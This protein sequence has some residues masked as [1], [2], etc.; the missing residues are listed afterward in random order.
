VKLKIGARLMVTFAIVFAFL[1]IV[2]VVATLQ[3]ASMNATTQAIVGLRAEELNLT[4]RVSAGAYRA[5]A[6]AYEALE[7]RT[8]DAQL[9]AVEQVEDAVNDNNALY[10]SIS[11]LVNTE[12]G[13]VI[14]DRVVQAHTA[15]QAA[16]SPVYAQ[17][18]VHD[19]A[20]AQLALQQATPLRDS[21]V[22]QQ[23]EFLD[24]V[25]GLMDA[26]GKETS[27]AYT[28]AREVLWI[29]ALIAMMVACV[30]AVLVTRS[31]VR[32]LQE[33][34]DG[35]NA[36]ARGDLSVHLDATREDEVGVLAGAL[37]TAIAQLGQIVSEVKQASQSISSATHQLA[38]GN[39]DLSQRTEEQAASLQ[40]TA[41]SMEQLTATV[42]QNADNAREAS[43]LSHTASHIAHRGGDKVERVVQTMRQISESSLRV[44]EIVSVIEGIAFQTNILA[45]NAAVEA[46]RAGEEGRGFAVVAGEVRALAQRSATAAR[47][48][49]ELIG[50]SVTRVK[51]G[52]ALVAD[53][54]GTIREIV[55]SVK[56]VTQ[57]M[58]EI[59]AASLEQSTGIEQVNQA[60]SEM[61]QV[62]QQNAALVEEAAAAAQSMTQQAQSLVASVAIFK[63]DETQSVTAFTHAAQV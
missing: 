20:N 37:D 55:H 49:A 46:A 28:S 63:L 54:G 17:L 21:L 50:E 16:M 36:L 39:T 1:I 42:R 53:A 26:S 24:Y 52:E 9:A 12:A 33:V 19:S 57:I 47:E 60:V 5:N 31:I 3:M 29:T 2:C 32:P 61:D 6:L 35:A 10:Q 45:L 34:V 58:G 56:R 15:Y 23:R 13:R 43:D 62:T 41:S 30:L 14:F 11:K 22:K 51:A 59:S 27:D 8:P 40:E 38:A 4:N 44:A 7:A 48:I 25:Q 18:R